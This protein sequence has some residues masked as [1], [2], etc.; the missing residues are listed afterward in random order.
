M[1]LPCCSL[2]VT[3]LLWQNDCKLRLWR[4]MHSPRAGKNS[5]ALSCCHDCHDM[6]QKHCTCRIL[7]QGVQACRHDGPATNAFDLDTC[8]ADKGSHKHDISPF[9]NKKLSQRASG[10]ACL[11]ALGRRVQCNRVILTAVQTAC[12]KEV[13]GAC[14]MLVKFNAVTKIYFTPAK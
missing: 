10:R 2:Q 8:T 1:T 7:H 9:R 11:H 12:P 3:C 14:R 5:V 13:T 4:L 6:C